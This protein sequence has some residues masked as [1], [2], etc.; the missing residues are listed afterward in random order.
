MPW[1]ITL[2]LAPKDSK[3]APRGLVH[4]SLGYHLLKIVQEST[5]KMGRNVSLMTKT[6]SCNGGRRIRCFMSG[7]VAIAGI[8]M[9]PRFRACAPRRWRSLAYS[10]AAQASVSGANNTPTSSSYHIASYMMTDLIPLH[11]GQRS[12]NTSSTHK[13]HAML[14]SGSKTLNAPA[15]RQRLHH[16][17]R[18]KV[19]YNDVDESLQRFLPVPTRH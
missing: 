4:C 17:Q 13:L 1:S 7:S 16:M 2:V 19:E 9:F 5:D 10:L 14:T 11:V 12:Q 8:A 3:M 15:L 6:A 18:H